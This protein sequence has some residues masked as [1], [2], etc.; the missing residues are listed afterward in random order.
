LGDFT[1][2]LHRSKTND[3]TI[4]LS[5]D[6]ANELIEKAGFQ[7]LAVTLIYCHHI[8]FEKLVISNSENLPVLSKLEIQYKQ[9]TGDLE[10]IQLTILDEKN[11]KLYRVESKLD[12][13]YCKMQGIVP[14]SVIYTNPDKT[15]RAI[16]S[17]QFESIR[18]FLALFS[19]DKIKYLKALRLESATDQTKV[20]DKYMGLSGEFTAEIINKMWNQPVNFKN[21]TEKSPLFSVLFDSW[22]KKLLGDNYQV[23]SQRS[24]RRDKKYQIIIEEI[25]QELT[26]ELNQVGVGISQ[27]LPMITLI[28]TSNEHDLLMIE[29]PEVHLHPKLQALFVEM[30]L[31]AVENNRRLVVETHSEH[32]INGL[33]YRVKEN[34]GYLDKISILFLEKSLGTIQYTDVHISKDGKLDFWPENFFDQ[35]YKDLLKLINK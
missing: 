31:F 14:E 19:E 34:P 20:Y 22:I 29:N 32:I 7:Y 12:N 16:C 27:L 21:E 9:N 15:E 33:R 10:T 26:L 11:S 8:V 5:V 1:G 17:P 2:V 35:N 28:L 3:E 18:E 23:R 24:T 4:E 6:F 30:C 13:G 25:K